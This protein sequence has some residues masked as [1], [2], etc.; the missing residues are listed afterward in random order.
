MNKITEEDI[1]AWSNYVRS[2]CGINLDSS[3]GYLFEN[4]LGYLGK[5]VGTIVW[6][7]LLYKIKSDQSGSLRRKLIDSITTNETSFFRDG[8][9]FDLLQFKILPDLIDKRKKQ[10]GRTSDIPLRI[11]S[12]AC[13]TGQEVYSIAIVIKELLGAMQGYDPRILGTDISDRVVS[14]ASYGKYEKNEIE[15]GLKPEKISKYFSPEGTQWKIRDE[16]RAL[17]TF[18]KI[19]L[20]EPFTF[21]VKFDIVFCRNVAIYFG[22]AD[23]KSL[24][25]RLG[26]VLAPDGYLIIGSTESITTICPEFQPHRYQRS[27]YYQHK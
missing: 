6:S 1:L 20:L 9:P 3:K 12:A 17:A 5:E 26:K 24:F 7:D 13:S 16:Y 27:V 25:Q 21:P 8:S 22:E 11:W 23:R 2:L 10:Q 14:K 15:R 4:R 18:K 19:N